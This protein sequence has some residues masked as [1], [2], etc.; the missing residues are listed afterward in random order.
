MWYN[1][2]YTK[3]GAILKRKFLAIVTQSCPPEQ[4]LAENRKSGWKIRR[5][6]NII[7]T[8]CQFVFVRTKIEWLGHVDT[9]VCA[10]APGNPSRSSIVP[11]ET[12]MPKTLI[13]V[14]RGES[15]FYGIREL[16]HLETND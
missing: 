10:M 1:T 7:R 14:F 2:K 12:C 5:L 15:G 3:F 9:M 8:R 13:V 4:N 6:R 16:S 11:C